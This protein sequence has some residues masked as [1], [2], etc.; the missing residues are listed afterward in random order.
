MAFAR[1]RVTHKCAWD[2][3]TCDAPSALKKVVRR[4]AVCDAGEARHVQWDTPLHS[5]LLVDSM[6]CF[7]YVLE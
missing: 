4:R 2:M 6:V 1:F 5:T 3:H 7:W